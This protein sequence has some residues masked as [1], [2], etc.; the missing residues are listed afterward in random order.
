MKEELYQ[1]I[2]NLAVFYILF[3]AILHLIPNDR[4]E[5]Y[6]RFFMGLL[7]I[8]M[9]SSPVFSLFGKRQ[10]LWDSFRKNFEMENL[11]KEEL[12]MNNIQ[13][14]YMKKGYE[15][16]IS[17]KI[18]ECLKKRGIECYKA[19]V[20]IEGEEIRAVI[21]LY[22]DPTQEQRG[23]IA[24]GLM[25]ECGLK[26]GEY[27]IQVVGNKPKKVDSLAAPGTFSGSSSSAGIS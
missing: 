21:K 19:E 15:T 10:E 6:V 12:E 9:M 13:K 25:E 4:Y 26:E 3:T 22:T 16:Q 7:L 17:E 24:D 27:Q 23:R 20:N 2:R 14:L 18:T 5:K 8:F 1:W 11:K